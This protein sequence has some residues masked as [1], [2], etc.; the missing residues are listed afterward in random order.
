VLERALA[1]TKDEGLWLARIRLAQDPG[2]ALAAAKRALARLP[3]AFRLR[4]AHVRAVERVPAW[5]GPPARADGSRRRCRRPLGDL[6]DAFAAASA[7]CPAE[8]APALALGRLAAERR[9]RDGSDAVA[10]A[11]ALVRRLSPSR[12]EDATKSAE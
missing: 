10:W 9:R 8:R 7:A 11:L 1:T 6:E 5:E 3:G 12:D 2:D 4:E